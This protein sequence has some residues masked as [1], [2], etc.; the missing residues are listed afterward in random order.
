MHPEDAHDLARRIE[1]V[2]PGYWTSVV[3]GML[4]M[5]CIDCGVSHSIM[6]R[7]GPTAHE[8]RTEHEP[9]LTEATRENDTLELALYR[10]VIQL[11]EQNAQ[12]KYQRE[13]LEQL[14]GWIYKVV[15]YLARAEGFTSIQFHD[16]V[17]RYLRALGKI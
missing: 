2:R 8:I 15:P 1:V 7:G 6:I 9:V 14:R 10:E 12:L 13:E 5:T 11:R 17:V 4:Y 16:E 3:N